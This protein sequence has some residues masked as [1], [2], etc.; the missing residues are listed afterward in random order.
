M[1]LSHGK[2]Y[3]Y[4]AL[5]CIFHIADTFMCRS[6]TSLGKVSP[7]D[8]SLNCVGALIEKCSVVYTNTGGNEI[9]MFSCASSSNKCG[10]HIKDTNTETINCC[11]D[12][13]QCNDDKFAE[14]CSA[15]FQTV[16]NFFLVAVSFIVITLLTG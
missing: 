14:K 7:P 2:Q 15:G 1:L 5:L 13:E 16:G 6:G 10:E 8:S 9:W 12:K 3:T 4:L 11:C